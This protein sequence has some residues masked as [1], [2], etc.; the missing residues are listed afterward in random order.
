MVLKNE[1][2]GCVCVCVCVGVGVVTA[3]NQEAAV[4]RLG[5][6]PDADGQ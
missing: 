2:C 6:V 3:P 1:L 4:T 5:V